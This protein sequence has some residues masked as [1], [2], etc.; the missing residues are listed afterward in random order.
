MTCALNVLGKFIPLVL[1][2]NMKQ[3]TATF[4]LVSSHVDRK[5]TGGLKS[6]KPKNVKQQVAVFMRVYTPDTAANFVLLGN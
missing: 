5:Q 6:Q 3:A 2:V 1:E 4:L